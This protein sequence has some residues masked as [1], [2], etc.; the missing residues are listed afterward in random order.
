M[1]N[2]LAIS[3][4]I[5]ALVC[6]I[7]VVPSFAIAQDSP[8][9]TIQNGNNNGNFIYKNSAPLRS[10]GVGTPLVGYRKEP[11]LIMNRN[12]S[13]KGLARIFD[14]AGNHIGSCPWATAHGHAGGRYRCTMKTASLRKKAVKNTGD[15]VVLIRIHSRNKVCVRIPDAG[16]CYGSVKGLCKSTIK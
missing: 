13:T 7:A 2:R 3:K 15:P 9:N 16:K 14:T 10:G 1:G 4:L 5:I 12:I 8:C 6:T 11:T